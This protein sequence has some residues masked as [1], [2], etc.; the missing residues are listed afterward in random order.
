MSDCQT[1]SWPACLRGLL[2]LPPTGWAR[3]G[4]AGLFWEKVG[5]STALAVNPLLPAS[6]VPGCWREGRGPCAP[7]L[8]QRRGGHMDSGHWR[9]AHAGPWLQSQCELGTVA[10]KLSIPLCPIKSLAEPAPAS[11]WAP[12]GGASICP[13]LRLV[14]PD[15]GCFQA[16]KSSDL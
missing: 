2:L 14:R 12:R 3:L 8:A 16:T 1:G 9:R 7:N 11:S 13:R 15:G 4:V 10:G 6:P 5:P